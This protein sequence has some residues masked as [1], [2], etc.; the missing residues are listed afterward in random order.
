MPISC[1]VVRLT[2]YS[3][4]L[5][6]W[7]GNFAMRLLRRWLLLVGGWLTFSV[8]VV[9][10]CDDVVSSKIRV[11]HACCRRHSPASKG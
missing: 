5:G 3:R 1:D 2:W 10:V 9:L 6:G 8:S 7:I 4:G 11:P